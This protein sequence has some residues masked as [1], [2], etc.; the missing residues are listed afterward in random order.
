MLMCNYSPYASCH[1]LSFSISACILL[2]RVPVPLVS[3]HLYHVITHMTP[4]AFIGINLNT[5]SYYKDALIM[6]CS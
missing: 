3:I 5:N 1:I 4:S 2:P 6:R